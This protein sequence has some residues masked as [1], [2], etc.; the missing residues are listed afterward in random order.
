MTKLRCSLLVLSVLLAACSNGSDEAG[1]TSTT[2]EAATTT[3]SPDATTT[4]GPTTSA[5]PPPTLLPPLEDDEITAIPVVDV[6][7]SS[8]C[9]WFD[10][11]E[12]G[13]PF[14][15]VDCAEHPEVTISGVVIH[16]PTGDCDD[17]FEVVVETEAPF[18]PGDP[19]LFE[20]V[21]IQLVG[22]DGR[23]VCA[24]RDTVPAEPQLGCL[25]DQGGL[26]VPPEDVWLNSID[27]LRHRYG[28]GS[29]FVGPI[30]ALSVIISRL[31]ADNVGPV[32]VFH[33]LAPVVPGRIEPAMV[34]LGEIVSEQ[35]RELVPQITPVPPDV[36]TCIVDA[37]AADHEIA[38]LGP[39]VG[40]GLA[41]LSDRAV[42]VFAVGFEACLPIAETYREQFASF[43]NLTDECVEA[44]ADA[45]ASE[46]DWASNI[47]AARAVAQGTITASE[48]QVTIDEFA[49]ATYRELDCLPEG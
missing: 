40:H 3:S 44:I 21:D 18:E 10:D 41:R 47:G 36:S 7:A 48:R 22:A 17:T 2:E 33:V 12:P 15:P 14:R 42:Q 37:I 35:I 28:P 38:A 24:V 9:E 27:G 25:D 45:A 19:Q 5:A 31:G 30:E 43:G 26:S 49:S 34:G 11:D 39:D 13:T 46:F 32:G 1:Q 29:D 23:L 4:S 8:T 16:C 6:V 20:S